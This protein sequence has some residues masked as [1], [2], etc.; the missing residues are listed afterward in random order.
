MGHQRLGAMPARRKW[1]EVAAA[2]GAGAEIGEIAGRAADAA[3]RELAQARTSPQVIAAVDLLARAPLAARDPDYVA[4]LQNLGLRLEQPPDLMELAGALVAALDRGAAGQTQSDVG[5]MA[6]LAAAEALTTVVGSDLPS[7]FGA[8]ADDVRTALGKYAAGSNFARLARQFFSRFVYRTLDY[9]LSRELAE[10][11]GAG[12]R[13][14]GVAD[15]RAFEAAL[16][17][18]CEEATRI[19]TDY[20]AGWYGKHV[21]QS[22]GLTPKDVRAFVAYSLTKLEA[23]LKAR[24]DG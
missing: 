17:T 10:H 7:L 2:L 24:R 19:V 12:K 11:H 8:D 3:Q 13:F 21:Y 5:E 20:A 6:K 4:E 1:R 14:S 15:R 16:E 18:H 23:E 9:Y 22:G